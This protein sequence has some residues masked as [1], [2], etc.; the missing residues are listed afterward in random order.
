MPLILSILSCNGISQDNKNVLLELLEKLNFRYYVTGIANRADTGQ[1]H[2]FCLAHQFFNHFGE[3]DGKTIN[4]LWLQEESIKFID[5]HASD[6]MFIESPTLDKDDPRDYAYWPGLKFFLASYEQ[7]L[8]E[9]A[10]RKGNLPHLMAPESKDKRE[11][12]SF[13]HKEHFWAIAENQYDDPEN[14]DVNKRRL[15]NFMLLNQG[16]NKAVKNKKPKEKFDCFKYPH[17][18]SPD[19]LMIQKASDTK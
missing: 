5:R 10:N 17:K 6:I 4:D 14:L 8:L 16:W 2:L 9:K 15:G 7:N 13:C 1:G 18:T 19:T 11:R 3:E 12:D